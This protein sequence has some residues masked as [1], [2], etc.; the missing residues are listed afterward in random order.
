MTD[1]L[2]MLGSYK[3]IKSLGK[4]GMGEVFLAYDPICKRNIA[5]KK[6]RDEYKN[7]KSV[8]ARF[9]KEA[10]IASQLTHPSIIPIYSIS[11]SPL[12][13]TMTYVEGETIKEILTKTKENPLHPIGGSISSLIRI[14][15]NVCEA[16]AYCH[17]KAIIHRDLKAENIIIGKYG[18]A[19]ILDWGI[20]NFLNEKK[21]DSDLSI[22]LFDERA[23]LTRPGK[24][25]GTISYMAPER[26]FGEN[27]SIHTDIYALGVILYQMLTLA[28]PFKRPN[29]ETFKKTAKL[30]KLI[31][32]IERAPFRD[33]PLQLDEIAKKC[34][35]S[36]KEGRY[37]SV[38]ELIY[39]IK[40][41]IEGKP[42][43]IPRADLQLNREEDWKFKENILLAKHIAITRSTEIAEWVSIM[44]S[45]KSF[46]GN[47]K[48]EADVKFGQ[49]S[50]GIGFLL[51]IPYN[52][53]HKDLDEG[54]CIWISTEK[55]KK[56][57]LTR[58]RLLI[59]E[60]DNLQAH[61]YSWHHIEIEKV[62]D[63]LKFYID[64]K[65]FFTYF[66][67]IPLYGN[68][69][70]LLFKDVNFEI[71][72][73]TISSNSYNVMVNC[74]TIPDAF[75]SKRNYDS[76]I[77]EYREIADSFPGRKEAREALFRSGITMLEKA[78]AQKI[79]KEKQLLLNKT[80]DE[81]EKLHATPG[82]PLEYLGKAMIYE[83]LEE[84][85][86][87]AKC[88]EL[89]LRK[90]KGHPLLS[91]L[92][93]Q[94]S[95]RLHESSKQSREAVLRLT[96]IALRHLP[97]IL[98]IP[99]SIQLIEMLEK[100]LEQP[101]FLEKSPSYNCLATKIA[102]WLGNKNALWEMAQEGMAPAFFALFELKAFREAEKIS[103]SA[104][105]VLQ[106]LN[107]SC[108]SLKNATDLFFNLCP[109]KLD[110]LSFNVLIFILKSAIEKEKFDFA[111]KTL[112]HLK[113]KHV[114]PSS[115]STYL[116]FITAELSL[117]LKNTEKSAQ[118]F[119]KHEES[120]KN[121]TSPFYFLYGCQLLLT[122]GADAAQRFFLKSEQTAHPAVF[123]MGALYLTGKLDSSQLKN[124][125]PSEKKELYKQ[126]VLYYHCANKEK[127]KK[128][129]KNL[130]LKLKR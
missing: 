14:F 31:S 7:N 93:E 117:F 38:E 23:D 129:F 55:E 71:Q 27:A 110:F 57:R 21:L 99:D 74:L 54:Y 128:H 40:S 97:E 87:E 130:S 67:H 94:L 13:Y 42:K 108:K 106:C 98:K 50:S 65:T 80:F 34:L 56:S 105:P 28:L 127:E 51:S 102:Y 124:I 47:I 86:E 69:I 37:S 70:G 52:S 66:S 68:Q 26:A 125:L 75:F 15:L 1:Q 22:E 49:K 44:I 116:D 11:F 79:K 83:Y 39:D 112:K 19:F 24:L 109:K 5:I 36:S 25:A 20:A 122:K 8:K 121:E 100:N 63:N 126:L 32:P 73:I 118:I 101:Y 6:I 92:K 4:G 18:E 9:L 58:S 60:F 48:I 90:F 76:A 59:K 78:K 113:E 61:D 88:L 43:W 95:Y 46:P 82:A 29:L 16:I 3:I 10:K 103:F 45:K 115:F 89:A 77:N 64:G 96:L 114:I 53:E 81:F 62:E 123:S 41:F 35:S 119:E 2:G 107:E 91:V 85:E 30:E 33:I 84:F 120:I 111:E 72:N 17:S 104:D 12:Y